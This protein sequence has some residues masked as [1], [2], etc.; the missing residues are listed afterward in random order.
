MLSRL[1]IVLFVILFLVTFV[2]NGHTREM[3]F[4]KC[5][6]I[7]QINENTNITM[8]LDKSADAYKFPFVSNGYLL[9][10]K[11]SPDNKFAF[12]VFKITDII[13]T[14][15]S[16]IKP[17]QYI[18]KPLDNDEKPISVLDNSPYITSGAF[19][20]GP[21]IKLHDVND[22]SQ[23]INVTSHSEEKD[24][25]LKDMKDHQ[26]KDIV[27]HKNTLYW[28]MATGLY[29]KEL[30]PSS[31]GVWGFVNWPKKVADSIKEIFKGKV[32]YNA[33]KYGRVL[34]SVDYKNNV[35]VIGYNDS[36]GVPYACIMENENKPCM[37]IGEKNS[38]Q[39]KLNHTASYIAV[40]SDVNDQGEVF[41]QGDLLVFNKKD[42]KHPVKIIQS[43]KTYDIQNNED[44]KYKQSYNWLDNSI[45]YLKAGIDNKLKLFRCHFSDD[46][47]NGKEEIFSFPDT[48]WLPHANQDE[49][50][51]RLINYV[52]IRNCIEK[53]KPDNLNDLN[54]LYKNEKCSGLNN[55]CREL[56]SD[57]ERLK[58]SLQPIKHTTDY[59]KQIDLIIQQLKEKYET[60]SSIFWLKKSSPHP[61]NSILLKLIELNWCIPFKYENESY[62]IAQMDVNI[63][64]DQRENKLYS[65]SS[66]KCYSR[67]LIFKMPGTFAQ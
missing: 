3:E 62:L 56:G 53:I 11:I 25:Q 8:S 10:T 36:K 45:Y 43:I 58:R 15:E 17:E 47:P 18:N 52:N 34:T 22:N 63:K 40:S 61:E 2:N 65:L 51:S 37:N 50:L 38:F 30:K 5:A 66:I 35:H 4:F 33:A 27:K 49:K 42:C 20:S 1:Y 41:C 59:P 48:I 16:W 64:P 26:L 9:F 14:R 54:H 23:I 39:P 55:I 19:F 12:Y 24:H 29:K 57:I 21:F 67:I 44:F 7:Y 31:D 60:S 13:K 32:L 28:C 6:Y 46:Y